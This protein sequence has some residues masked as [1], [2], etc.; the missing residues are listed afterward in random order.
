MTPLSISPWQFA[1]TSTHFFASAHS[2]ERPSPEATLIVNDLVAG[3]ALLQ[4]GYWRL[5]V[6]ERMF[7]L[8]ADGAPGIIG[9]RAVSSM[10]E[11]GTSTQKER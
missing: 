6:H 8:A 1:H 2:F 4:E 3:S 10:A 11:R 5:R 7:A 9:P